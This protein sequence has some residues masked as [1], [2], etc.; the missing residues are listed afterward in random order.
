MR[1][2]ESRAIIFSVIF[3]GM[4]IPA[5]EANRVS[6][7]PDPECVSEAVDRLNERR[8]DVG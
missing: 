4:L 2:K 7:R 6:R 3:L 1:R 8:A 5:T